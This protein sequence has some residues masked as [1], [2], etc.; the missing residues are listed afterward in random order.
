MHPSENF[1]IYI[2]IYIKYYCYSKKNSVTRKHITLLDDDISVD[3]TD[4]C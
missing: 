2:Y 1:D 3:T 4:S